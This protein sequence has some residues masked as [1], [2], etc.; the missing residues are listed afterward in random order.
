MKK[1]L[2]LI[3][4]AAMLFAVTVQAQNGAPV[5]GFNSVYAGIKLEIGTSNFPTGGYLIDVRK[6]GNVAFQA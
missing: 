2:S 6:M 5:Y 4:A 1:V 3:G